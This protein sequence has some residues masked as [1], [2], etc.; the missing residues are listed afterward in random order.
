MSIG[1]DVP[2]VDSE[3]EA[4]VLLFH[5]LALAAAYFE[6]TNPALIDRVPGN[7][8]DTTA[9]RAWVVAMEALYPEDEA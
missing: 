7:R 6:A 4:E 2:G 3:Q 8:F 5:H 1:V 9:V